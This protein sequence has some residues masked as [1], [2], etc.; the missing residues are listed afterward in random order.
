MATNEPKKWCWFCS[1]ETN[2]WDYLGDRK[3]GVCGGEDCQREL[4]RA[5]QNRID[6]AAYEAQQ[7]HYSRYL[8]D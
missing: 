4:A 8:N 2:D 5:N 1:A 3:V 7:D 6:D